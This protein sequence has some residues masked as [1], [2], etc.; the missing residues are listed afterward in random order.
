MS[1]EFLQ[2]EM[3]LCLWVHKVHFSAGGISSNGGNIT[4]DGSNGTT[5]QY[6]LNHLSASGGNVTISM[7]GRIRFHYI[8]NR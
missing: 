3:S 7:G 4:I 2:A 5:G 1:Q 6:D 8:A